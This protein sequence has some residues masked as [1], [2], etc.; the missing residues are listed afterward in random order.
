MGY[1]SRSNTGGMQF[2]CTKAGGLLDKHD[3]GWS[4][5]K[6]ASSV[7]GVSWKRSECLGDFGIISMPVPFFFSIQPL[8]KPL[9]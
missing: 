6:V 9:Y 2:S 7:L 3:V 8:N 5:D 4:G 1:H